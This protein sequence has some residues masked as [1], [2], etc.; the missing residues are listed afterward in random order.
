MCLCVGMALC[1]LWEREQECEMW[2]NFVVCAS[3][4]TYLRWWVISTYMEVVI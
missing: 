3:V 1:F 4:S 2:T